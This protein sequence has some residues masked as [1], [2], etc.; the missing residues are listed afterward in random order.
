M[1]D[2]IDDVKSELVEIINEVYKIPEM[3]IRKGYK[4]LMT[5]VDDR[6]PNLYDMAE[7]CSE[8]GEQDYE[9]F[10]NNIKIIEEQLYSLE[11]VTLDYL[12]EAV[13]ILCKDCMIPVVEQIS[14]GRFEE[15]SSVI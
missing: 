6:A 11:N 2:R 8:L 12:P 15:I 1:S 14:E 10:T 7:E 13:N 4:S 3:S 5:I 9:M